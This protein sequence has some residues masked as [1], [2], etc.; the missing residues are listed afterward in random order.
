SRKR[1]RAGLFTND[2]RSLL[3]AFGD[4][5]NPN[6]ETVAVLEDILSG[7]I[8]DLCH[9]ASKFSRTAGRAK[10][11]VDDFKFALRKDPQK[12]GRVEELLAMQKLIR[13]AK[14]TFD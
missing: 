5:K 8:V 10:V 7:Y 12:I 6:S 4:V 13:D 14:K 11:K 9:E 1:K 3:Y 2:V